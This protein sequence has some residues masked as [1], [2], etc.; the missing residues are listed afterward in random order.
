VENPP[1][2]AELHIYGF[3]KVNSALSITAAQAI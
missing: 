2:A 3:K 1:R